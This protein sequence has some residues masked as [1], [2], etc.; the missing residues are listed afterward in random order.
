MIRELQEQFK[1]HS[2]FSSG[3]LKITNKF[4]HE[5]RPKHAIVLKASSADS[6]KLALDNFK[7][8][9]YSYVTLANLKNKP[10]RM[11]VCVREDNV[12][13]KNLVDPGFY[14]VTMD[15][16]TSF[17]VDPYLAIDSEVLA[18]VNVGFYKAT[19]AHTNINAGSEL[20]L[21]EDGIKLIRDKHYTIDNG[22][23]EISFL[24]PI[25]DYGTMTIDYQYLGP[26]KG[27]FSVERETINN[28]AIPGVI[29]AFG[30]FLEKSGTQVVVVYP[31]RQLVATSY[32]G[33]F[34]VGVDF[35]IVSQDTDTQEQLVDLLV[36]FMWGN[37]Q[38]KLVNDGIYIE[39]FNLSGE[40][41]E[42]EDQIADEMSYLGGLSMV[43]NVEWEIFK[44]VLG[45]VKGVFLNRVADF[46][47]YDERELAA[48]TSRGFNESQR[49][50][51]HSVGLQMVESVYPYMVRPVIPYSLYIPNKVVS[52]GN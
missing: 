28:D 35:S 12:N 9:V 25:E 19:I 32:I 48:R 47:Q 5:E 15:T 26:R 1:E 20:I 52:D 22:S 39:D 8:E 29:L 7:G 17:I 37:L 40:T 2:L 43:A 30:N 38:D 34:K 11:I 36:M 45:V 31:D 3:D 24:V 10:G 41:E 14:V 46:G 49:G 23:G 27:P 51:D 42:K 50:V 4:T 13:V 16:N 6:V 44:P 33:K 18:P 21:T